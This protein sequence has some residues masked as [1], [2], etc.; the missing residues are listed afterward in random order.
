[1]PLFLFFGSFILLILLIYLLGL[2]TSAVD[3][4]PL[5]DAQESEHERS[6][7]IPDAVNA[8]RRSRHV[9]ESQR[10]R[11]EKTTIVILGLTGIFALAAAI[12][13][14]YSAYIFNQQTADF[15]DQEQRQLRAYVFPDSVAIYN[16]DD[17]ISKNSTEAPR[18]EIFMRN[19]GV[20]PAYNVTTFIGAG[21]VAFPAHFT[22]NDFHIAATLNVANTSTNILAHDARQRSVG[23]V[24]NAEQPLTTAQ[25]VSLNNGEIAIY[26]YGE[27]AYYDIFEIRRCTR[28]RYYVGGDAGFHGTDMTNAPEGQEADRNCREPKDIGRERPLLQLPPIPHVPIRLEQVELR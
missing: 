21:L 19:T 28:F 8:Y 4:E 9:H 23:V 18:V 27:T 12:A 7:T 22:M 24:F 2:I 11:R 25:K 5:E 20:T 10:A 3:R 13:A 26:F 15:V 6:A 1:M 17:D 14:G 16:A